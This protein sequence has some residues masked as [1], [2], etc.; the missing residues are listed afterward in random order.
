MLAYPGEEGRRPKQWAKWPLA[1]YLRANGAT[2]KDT[3]KAVGIAV[4]TLIYWEQDPRWQLARQTARKLWAQ[5]IEEAAWA[6]IVR[7]LA[8]NGAGTFALRVLRELDPDAL[9]GARGEAQDDAATRTGT[10]ARSS[11]KLEVHLHGGRYG[12]D[13]DPELVADQLQKNKD[14]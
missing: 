5:H 11:S 9:P 14:G 3:A 6:A 10:R 7:Q 8:S 1:A 12:F 13:R 2:Q 4:R